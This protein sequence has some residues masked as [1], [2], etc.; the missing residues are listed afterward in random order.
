MRGVQQSVKGRYGSTNMFKVMFVDKKVINSMCQMMFG[1]TTDFDVD[2]LLELGAQMPV[3]PIVVPAGGE[4]R[5]VGY[6]ANTQYT[7]QTL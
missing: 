4:R 1:Q 6:D 5:F 7:T 3:D 2:A